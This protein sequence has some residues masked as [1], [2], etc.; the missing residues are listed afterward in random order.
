[1]LLL[2]WLFINLMGE[3]RL[4]LQTLILAIISLISKNQKAWK[5]TQMHESFHPC[6]LPTQASHCSQN[7]Q[8]YFKFC[9]ITF[10]ISL[11]KQKQIQIEVFLFTLRVLFNTQKGSLIN[12]LFWTLVFQLMSPGDFLT[13]FTGNACLPFYSCIVSHHIDIHIL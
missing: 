10:R 1:M 9:S 5:G 4:P 2:W 12:T 6:L 8:E 13:S 11:Y 7:R 3:A